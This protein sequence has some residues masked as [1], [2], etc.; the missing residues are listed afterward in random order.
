M[1]YPASSVAVLISSISLLHVVRT[2]ISGF[3]SR[4]A[5]NVAGSSEQS[6]SVVHEAHCREQERRIAA[7]VLLIN[8]HLLAPSQTAIAVKIDIRRVTG[9]S[10]SSSSLGPSLDSISDFLV[11]FKSRASVKP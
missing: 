2:S 3:R 4:R 9:N 6:L 5:F 7:N 1:S 8:S 11:N 10:R